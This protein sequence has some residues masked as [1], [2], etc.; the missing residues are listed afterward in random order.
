MSDD[1]EASG[2]STVAAEDEAASVIAGVLG[3]DTDRTYTRSELA[4]AADIPL[5]TLYLLETLDQLE[6][7]GMLERVDDREAESEPQFAIDA[8]SDLYHAAKT[9]DETFAAQLEDG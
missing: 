6:R 2:W 3:L 8:D 7:A 5:K 1:T 4:E 9:F